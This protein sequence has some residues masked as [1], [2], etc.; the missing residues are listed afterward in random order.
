MGE[1]IITHYGLT[2]G[3]IIDEEDFPVPVFFF[4]TDLWA[5]FY[6]FSLTDEFICSGRC[7]LLTF[8]S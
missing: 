3:V 5:A 8:P 2:A 6:V 7:K 4:D 1:W